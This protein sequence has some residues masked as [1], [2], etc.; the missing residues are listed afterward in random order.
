[1]GSGQRL[2]ATPD[3]WG[4][5]EGEPSLGP[6]AYVYTEEEEEDGDDDIAELRA[7]NDPWGEVYVTE[8]DDSSDDESSDDQDAFD[9]AASSEDDKR[10]RI[11]STRMSRTLGR[12]SLRASLEE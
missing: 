11:K 8:T 9:E 3:E 5:P 2:T 12:R 1:M 6:K 10:M 7:F 4:E